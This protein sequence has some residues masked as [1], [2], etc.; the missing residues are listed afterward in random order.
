MASA[1]GDRTTSRALR[2][3][4]ASQLAGDWVWPHWLRRQL[5]PGSPAHVPQGQLPLLANVTGRTWTAVGNRGSALAAVVDPRG[6]VSPRH[7]GWSLDWWVGA[8]DR[9]HV[10][11]D[12]AGVRQAL[13]G[14]APVVETRMRVP[15]GDVIHRAY[16]MQSTAADGGGELVVVEVENDTAVP[17]A[18]ALAIRPYDVEGVAE[19]E[20]IALEGTTV[21]VDGVA[22]VLLPKAPNAVAASTFSDGDSATTVLAGETT[23]TFPEEL[24]DE[25]GLAQA[26]FVFAL[27]H[28]QTLRI[29]LPLAADG[30]GRSS[31]RRRRRPTAVPFPQAV[32]SAEQVANGW[33]AHTDRGARIVLPDDRLQS[34]VEANRRHLLVSRADDQSSLRDVAAVL[35]ALDRW[36]FHDEARQVLAA[37]PDRQRS[38]GSLAGERDERDANGAALWALGHHWDLTRDRTLLDELAPSVAGAVQ[39][40]EDSRRGRRGRR[41][42]LSAGAASDALDPQD[43]PPRD[44][45]GSLAGLRDGARLLGA[46]GEDEAADRACDFLAS[47]T[48]D[49]RASMASAAERLGTSAVPAGPDRRLDA[50]TVD[51]IAAVWPLQLLGPD[52]QSMLATL[53]VVRDRFCVDHAVHQGIGPTGLGT[54]LTLQ[55]ATAELLAGDRRALDR[56][57]WFLSAATP[58]WTWPELVHPRTGGGCGG[59]GHDLAAAAALLSF[60]RTMLV[61]ETS[62]GLALASMLPTSW[63]G[64]GVEVHDAPT[65]FGTVSFA[66]RWHGE[67][68]AILWELEPHDPTVAVVLTSPGLDPTWRSTEARGDALLAAPADAPVPD[69]VPGP[70]QGDSFG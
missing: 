38:D 32:P 18:L 26:A 24:R 19:V 53:D 62:E 63:Y 42:L 56:L 64:Q 22:A 2:T 1:A 43:H 37:H 21:I 66:I 29:V 68:P 36:G 69:A 5:D 7:A 3:A 10:P 50:G 60:V 35:A 57:D 59:D 23:S 39:W 47:M 44:D 28:R 46:A 6:L 40:I 27:P 70:D 31:G 48:A 65:R 20:H 12:E 4:G 9:W 8:E 67:R 41:S 25:V 14:D 54:G 13:L 51:T 58:T 49:V 15:G 16:A 30:L 33:K 11:A 55:V 17:V 34:A 52:D 61:H 45:L